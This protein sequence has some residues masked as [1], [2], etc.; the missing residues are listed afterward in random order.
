VYHGGEF[1][2]TYEW[3]GKTSQRGLDGVAC[4]QIHDDKARGR[5]TDYGPQRAWTEGVA[6]IAAAPVVNLPNNLTRSLAA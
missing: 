6:H 2:Y 4:L 5:Q 3:V 1:L